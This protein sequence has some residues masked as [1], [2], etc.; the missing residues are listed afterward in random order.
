MSYMDIGI[1]PA[2]LA[3]AP[4]AAI[5]Q[6]GIDYRMGGRALANPG[7]WDDDVIPPASLAQV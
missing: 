5:T 2:V 6:V 7:G 3:G 1:G 4:H